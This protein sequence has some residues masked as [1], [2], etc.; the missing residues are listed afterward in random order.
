MMKRALYWALSL[1]L[2]LTPA[3]ATTTLPMLGLVSSPIAIAAPVTLGTLVTTAASRSSI[4]LTTTAAI[5]SGALACVAVFVPST[6]TNSVIGVTDTIN[7]YARVVQAVWDVST[8]VFAELWCKEN[9]SALSSAATIS[10]SLSI[11][12]NAQPSTASAFY[13][14]G[15]L[16]ASSIDKTNNGTTNSGTAYASGSTGTLAQAN[17]IAIGFVGEYNVSVTL[18]DGAGFTNLNATAQGGTPFF[19]TKLSY[20]IVAA[21]TALNYQPSTSSATFGKT[22][23]ATF[24]GH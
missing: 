23:I 11:S 22:L 3:S 4:T 19:N 6:S 5:P 10:V 21:T 14:T 18:T 9:A 17:E 16:S 8:G 24:E 20:Q 7:V 13:V 15:T 12:T 2:A 1:G